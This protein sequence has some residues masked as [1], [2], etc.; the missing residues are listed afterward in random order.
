MNV[1]LIVSTTQRDGFDVV[2]T[3]LLFENNTD[4]TVNILWWCTFFTK[5]ENV[6][7]LQEGLLYWW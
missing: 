7:T 2:E 6:A 3:W 4:R 5:E 1:L